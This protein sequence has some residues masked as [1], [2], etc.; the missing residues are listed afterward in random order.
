MSSLVRRV[1]NI[2]GAASAGPPVLDRFVDSLVQTFENCRPGLPDE[3]LQQGIERASA[4]FLDLYEKEIPRLLQIIHEEEPLLTSEAREEVFEKVDGLIKRVVIP[5]YAR[6]S[7]SFT[8]RQRNDFYALREPWHGVERLGWGF[9]GMLL[10]VFIIWAPF[11]PIWSKEWVV[12]FMI[13][14][15]FFPNIR[16]YLSF[17]RYANEINDLVSRTDQEILRVCR[18]YLTSGEALAARSAALPEAKHL[19]AIHK[20]TAFTKQGGS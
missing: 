7:V 19:P 18:A 5:A 16:R 4:F 6:V 1:L 15:L 17:R 8:S 13:A 11:I 14:G 10:G 9:A 3:A 2:A 20:E 12:P